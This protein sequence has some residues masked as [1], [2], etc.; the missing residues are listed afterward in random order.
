MILIISKILTLLF[1]FIVISKSIVDYKNKN[2]NLTMAIFWIVVWLAITTIAFFPSIVDSA[3]TLAGGSRTGLGTVFGIAIIFVLFVS[4]RIYVKSRRTERQIEK[5]AQY[6]AI[7][8]TK[9]K[10]NKS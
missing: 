9:I 10:G 8:K 6:I 4:Y 3:I 1:A 5:L 2:E 7:E